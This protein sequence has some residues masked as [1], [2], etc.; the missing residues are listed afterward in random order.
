M[1]LSEDKLYE[2]N[3]VFTR[4]EQDDKL[5]YAQESN[6]F[7][8][9]FLRATISVWDNMSQEDRI[10]EYKKFLK[11]PFTYVNEFDPD[12]WEQEDNSEDSDKEDN[13]EETFKL[14]KDY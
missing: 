8:V 10:E 9:N 5:E 1:A 6:K 13:K 7:D 12:K 11:N 14:F 2:D 3:Y 4:D